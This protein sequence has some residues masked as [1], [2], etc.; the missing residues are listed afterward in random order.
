MNAVNLVPVLPESAPFTVEQR[1][2]LN[3]FL[4][5]L[6]SRAS[7]TPGPQGAAAPPRALE[8]VTILFGSQTGT[9]EKLAKRLAKEAGKRGFAP[10]LFEMANYPTAQLAAE[11]NLLVVASTYGDGEPPDN[12]KGFARFLEGEAAPRLTT[13]RFTVCALG[14]SNYPQFCAFGK[15][16]DQRFEALG[17][18]RVAPRADCDVEFDRPF[19]AWMSAALNALAPGEVAV[20]EAG[21]GD[22]RAPE[23]LEEPEETFGRDRPFPAALVLNR[24]LNLEGSTKDT[25][26]LSFSLADSGL[27]Y[28]TGDALGVMPANCPRLVTELLAALGCTGEE[29]VQI[30]PGVQGSL[31]HA[32]ASHCDITRI[33]LDLLRA[34]AT[35]TQDPNLVRVAAPEANGE[36][37]RFLHGR[38][39]IDLLLAHPEVRFSPAQFTALLKP[40]R[41][42]LYSIASSPK[43]HPGEVHLCV[44]VVRYESLGRARLGVCSTFLADR[45][46]ANA[47][48]PVYIHANPNFRLPA[49][50]GRPVIMVGPGTGI[51]PFRAFLEERRAVGARGQNW[52]FFGDQRAATDYLFREEIEAMHAEGT[53]HRL[54]LAFSRDQAEKVYV[55]HRMLAH[56]RELFAWL[57]AGA[58]FYVCGDAGR[59]AKDVDGALKQ[60]V[61]S[62]GG[63]TL[64]QATEYVQELER[65]KRYVRDVY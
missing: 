30:A 12:A 50:T 28:E 37:T 41:P 32:L 57:E 25:R 9:A 33:P 52:L 44:G 35:R 64:A 18:H 6:F 21:S 8:P 23:P 2:Y 15:R 4:A 3:G 1:A 61:Q 62:G 42:R 51:A 55:Q 34:V 59:M 63:R 40:L 58:H 20:Q 65:Q 46:A 60:I 31:R 53:L 10:T 27:T 11:R 26:H 45:L 13:T 17:A 48:A 5:G 39:V 47:C 29:A 16:L 43:A 49:D 22:K 38:E 24:R 54:E 56:A 19:L 7:A 14:D 36:L